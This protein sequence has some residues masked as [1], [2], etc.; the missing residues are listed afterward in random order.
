MERFIE[1]QTELNSF[2]QK[3]F[4]AFQQFRTS[5]FD[6]GF[7]FTAKA[8]FLVKREHNDFTVPKWAARAAM[9]L[10]VAYE[11]CPSD[12][13]RLVAFNRFPR[14]HALSFKIS[15]KEQMRS[16]TSND[17]DSSVFIFRGCKTWP[18][19]CPSTK[20]TCIRGLWLAGYRKV[21]P[22]SYAIIVNRWRHDSW[23]KRFG[24]AELSGK[25]SG[26][27]GGCW[28]I[29]HPFNGAVVYARSQKD[30]RRKATKTIFAFYRGRDVFSLLLPIAQ[31]QF[32]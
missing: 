26:K 29:E 5:W 3:D 16:S 12:G 15:Q 32:S 14:Q 23:S 17:I 19:G 31:F 7:H 10:G 2:S 4:L 30:W 25:R 13:R 6:V 8:I 9:N 24:C 20:G 1:F 22:G 27:I 11:C 21:S 18:E 28:R